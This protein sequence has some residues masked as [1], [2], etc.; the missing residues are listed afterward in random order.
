MKN[1]N[2]IY[3]SIANWRQDD[4]PDDQRDPLLNQN[5]YLGWDPLLKQSMQIPGV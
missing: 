5:M 2:V 4:L 3:P 1:K